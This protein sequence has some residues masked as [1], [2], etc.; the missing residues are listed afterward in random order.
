MVYIKKQP[1]EKEGHIDLLIVSIMI[2]TSLLPLFKTVYMPKNMPAQTFIKLPN[3][4]YSH[5]SVPENHSVTYKC[6]ISESISGVLIIENLIKWTRLKT[7]RIIVL[8]MN[9][10]LS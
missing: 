9:H 2:Q 5:D 8:K 4:V 6:C 3:V 1:T 7:I 10:I